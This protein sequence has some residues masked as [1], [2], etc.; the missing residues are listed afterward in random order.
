MITNFIKKKLLHITNELSKYLFH[1][2]QATNGREYRFSS[3]GY[4][5]LQ[6]NDELRSITYRILLER[7]NQKYN[8]LNGS[9]KHLLKS[10]INNV[11]N[12]NLLSEQIEQ[13]VD[14]VKKNLKAMLPS[15][16]DKVTKIKLKEAI[17][18]IGKFCLPDDSAVVKDSSVLQL[19]RYY[20]LV[21]EIKN[22]H[23]G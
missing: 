6:Y 14:E 9:Q 5:K 12:T 1:F 18:S 10:Y 4:K 11:S 22:V 16:D 20:E 13:E 17:N 7:F 15:V 21:K 23:E 19:M 2:G 8:Y 3:Q